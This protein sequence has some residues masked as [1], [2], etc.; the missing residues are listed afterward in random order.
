LQ[1]GPAYDSKLLFLQFPTS[2]IPLEEVAEGKGAAR[3]TAVV[4]GEPGKCERRKKNEIR[5]GG[6]RAMG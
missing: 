5:C 2:R 4:L 6:G 3:V 1:A